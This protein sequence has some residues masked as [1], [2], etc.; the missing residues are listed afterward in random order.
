MFYKL[1]N[2]VMVGRW[3]ACHH[4]NTSN[5]RGYHEQC[6]DCHVDLGRPLVTET[7]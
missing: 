5:L 1:Y 6:D 7:I 2:L 4:Q 3:T